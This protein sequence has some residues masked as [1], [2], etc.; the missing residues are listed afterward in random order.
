MTE[1]VRTKAMTN[2]ARANEIRVARA[3]DKRKIARNELDAGAVLK[4]PPEHWATAKVVELLVAVPRV[5]EVKVKQWCR[6]VQISPERRLGTMTTR[7]R[8]LLARTL[9][10]WGLRRCRPRRP[11]RAPQGVHEALAS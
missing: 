9:E 8:M 4:N 3:G 6:L 2:L 7:E 10:T 5:G 11:S 1:D